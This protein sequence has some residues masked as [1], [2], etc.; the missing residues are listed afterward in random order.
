MLF[1]LFKVSS[2]VAHALLAAL[3]TL[4]VC[5]VWSLLVS[6]ACFAV[7]LLGIH[8]HTDMLTFLRVVQH[9]TEDIPS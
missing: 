5:L 6:Y 3:R 9:Y 8:S 4:S 1:V 2:R 7:L